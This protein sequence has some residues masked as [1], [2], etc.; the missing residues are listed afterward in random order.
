MDTKTLPNADEVRK[1]LRHIPEDGT[2]VWLPRSDKNASWNTRH[3]GKI[4]GTTDDKGY[5]RIRFAGQC[6][7]LHRLVWLVTTGSWPVGRLDHKSRNTLD[8]RFGNLR[9]ATPWQNRQNSG[10]TKQN[11][12]GYKC[13]SA[14]RGRWVSNF[15]FRGKNHHAGYFDAPED[16]HAAYAK[17]IADLAGEFHNTGA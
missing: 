10:K 15:R 16:A 12:S 13:V 1:W 7:L 6:H 14:F 9:E 8:N 2:F 17:A 4:A 3:A 11:T 5:R